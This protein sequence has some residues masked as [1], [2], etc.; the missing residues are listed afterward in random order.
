MANKHVHKPCT[1]NITVLLT[2]TLPTLHTISALYTN[3][4][5]VFGIILPTL[6]IMHQMANKRV[7]KPSYTFT[8]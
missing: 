6:H 3:K 2:Q 1:F 4:Y 7:R 8:F 5:R